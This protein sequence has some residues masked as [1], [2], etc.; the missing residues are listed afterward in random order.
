MRLRL[1]GGGRISKACTRITA[2]RLRERLKRDGIGSRP[3]RHGALL[4]L[5]ARLPAPILAERLRFHQARAAQWV[6]AA[7]AGYADYVRRTHLALR[8]RPRPAMRH[9]EVAA[10]DAKVRSPLTARPTYIF[11]WSRSDM[12]P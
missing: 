11:R 7:G 6:R 9:R 12:F 4:A 10:S 5:G 1:N 2:E 8:E 3:S